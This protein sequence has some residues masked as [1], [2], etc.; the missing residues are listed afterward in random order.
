MQIENKSRVK[1]ETA[2]DQKANQ[3]WREDFSVINK[4]TNTGTSSAEKLKGCAPEISVNKD[5]Q[6]NAAPGSPKRRKVMKTRIDERG[7]EGTYVLKCV[8]FTQQLLYF[9]IE[10]LTLCMNIKI[11]LELPF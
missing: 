3:P 2:S 5:S 10:K 4:C 8:I 6:N 9:L 11:T 7:R 1:E